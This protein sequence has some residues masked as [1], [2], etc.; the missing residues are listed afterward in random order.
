[1]G[2][3]AVTPPVGLGAE[4]L[5]EVAW[6]VE[7]LAAS[8]REGTDWVVAG[9]AAMGSGASVVEARNVAGADWAKGVDWARVA[10]AGW[11]IGVD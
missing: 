5:A 1:M 2:G 8:A 4:A 9:R 10:E 7:G 3:A 11:V 6:G